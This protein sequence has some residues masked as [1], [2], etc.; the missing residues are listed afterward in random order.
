MASQDHKVTIEFCVNQNNAEIKLH[1]ICLHVVVD[2]CNSLGCHTHPAPEFQVR[3]CHWQNRS[4]PKKTKKLRI[5]I[6]QMNF[7]FIKLDF[8]L[9]CAIRTQLRPSIFSPRS[10]PRLALHT[11]VHVH[12]FEK[13]RS[14]RDGVGRF[15]ELRDV[16]FW[17][18]QLTSAF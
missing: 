18:W 6:Y 8:K 3:V 2:V 15:E 14:T 9:Q 5:S 7:K 13:G 10:R 4:C 16:A 11:V 17:L 1:A 12:V